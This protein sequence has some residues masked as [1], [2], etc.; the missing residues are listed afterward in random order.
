MKRCS[1]SLLPLVAGFLAL[2]LS[3][4]DPGAATKAQAARIEEQIKVLQAALPQSQPA[5]ASAKDLQD[6][7]Q[8]I[9]DLGKRLDK[10]PAAANPQDP[11]AA[12]EAVVKEIQAMVEPLQKQVGELAAKVAEN[13]K[14][15]EV[16]WANERGARQPGPATRGPVA[17]NPPAQPG[18]QPTTRPAT[19]PRTGPKADSEV[20]VLW[21]EERGGGAR[22]PGRTTGG[23]RAGRPPPSSPEEGPITMPDTTGGGGINPGR[24]GSEGNSNRD[25]IDVRWPEERR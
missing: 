21:P 2:G 1:L 18:T 7:K 12:N 16:E 4:C 6:I 5:G 8:Q 25:I 20:N 9:A 13:T 23:D 3:S 22:Q 11:Q 10:L 14:V 19:P 17:Q 24:Q 15:I